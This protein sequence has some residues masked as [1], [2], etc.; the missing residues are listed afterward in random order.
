MHAVT[1]R[2]RL[3]SILEHG[4]RLLRRVG[5][6]RIVDGVAGRVAPIVGTFA[7]EVDGLQLEGDHIGQLYYV[8][9]LAETGREAYFV[10][11]LTAAA[12][13]G[14]TVLEGGAHIGYLTLQAARSV[15]P[16]GE[17]VCFEPNPR[18]VPVLERN[19][20]ANGFQERVRIVPAALG[21]AHGRAELHITGGG[22]TSSLHG[23]A[24]AGDVVAVEVTTADSALPAPAT[25]DVVK[26]DVEG[27][28]VAALEGMRALLERSAPGPV[29][30]L[31]CNPDLLRA[32]GSSED[33]LMTLLDELGFEP[34]WLDEA[35]R[36]L[37]RLDERDGTEGYVNLLCRR[38]PAS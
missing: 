17:V 4:A 18:T 8:R 21:R 32:A 9:E 35:G 12:A 10:E 15:G 3:L 22:D 16:D 2:L 11:Q 25:V 14:A 33:E 34:R 26:L 6:G 7:I 28:E 23:A 29:L 36:C 30:F 24:A 19:V 37:R 31:E 5:L 13:P 20:A 27:A 1:G 38:R